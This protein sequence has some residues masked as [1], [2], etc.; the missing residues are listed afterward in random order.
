MIKNFRGG[1]YK[2]E[3]AL[4]VLGYYASGM[5]S[6]ARKL[7]EVEKEQFMQAFI[8]GN[9]D[10]AALDKLINEGVKMEALYDV[11]S[12][13]DIM[14]YIFELGVFMEDISTGEH[15]DQAPEHGE[16]FGFYLIELTMALYSGLELLEEFDPLGEN[17]KSYLGSLFQSL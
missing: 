10:A 7:W 1:Y 16:D 14:D 15:R 17:T 9:K 6:E 5:L 13:M 2:G 3:H 4:V 12:A 8:D 11:Q